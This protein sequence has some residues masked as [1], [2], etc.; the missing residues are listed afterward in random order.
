MH[1]SHSRLWIAIAI[2]TLTIGSSHS[3]I[4]KPQVKSPLPQLNGNQRVLTKRLSQTNLAKV[5]VVSATQSKVDRSLQRQASK[6]RG[7]Q[8]GKNRIDRADRG[9]SQFTAPNRNLP[10]AADIEAI[11]NLIE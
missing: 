6:V 8:P 3:V 11:N 4:A 10:R 5:G 9:I 2:S 1:H 7:S